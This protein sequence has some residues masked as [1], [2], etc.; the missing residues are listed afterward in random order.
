MKEDFYCEYSGTG[1][2][3]AEIK[4]ANYIFPLGEQVWKCLD[5]NCP[6]HSQD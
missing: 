4:Y 3:V 6:Y 1:Y 5:S 2:Y